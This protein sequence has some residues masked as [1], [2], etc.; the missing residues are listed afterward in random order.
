MQLCAITDEISQDFEYSLDVLREYGATGAELRGLWGTN[1]SALTDEQ[2]SR[3]EAALKARRM[4]VA[5]LATPFYKCDLTPDAPGD[6]PLEKMLHLA[7][8]KTLEE[9][10]DLLKRCIA[11]A[12][13]FETDLIRV[14]TF[15]RKDVLSPQIEDRIVAAYQEPVAMAE[16][17]GVILALENE[18]AC[19]VGTGVEA[20][21]I[22]QKIDSPWLRIC[23]DP[24]NALCAGERPYPDGYEAVRSSLAHI[25]IKDARAAGG[26]DDGDYQWCVVGEGDIDY[27]GHFDALKRDGY[28]GYISLETHYKPERGSG[29]DGVGT[30][31]DGSRPCLAAL[32]TLMAL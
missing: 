6:G 7:Q 9:Q 13:R 15:W 11:L 2:A 23:W 1:I 29:P 17:E 22:V 3:A 24:G 21:R 8:E 20:A 30:G 32:R 26:S 14:F 27:K 25:H 16:R 12:K 28:T 31:E 19:F 5:C 18:H 4:R 10:I